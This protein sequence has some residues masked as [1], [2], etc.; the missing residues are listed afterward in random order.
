M[1]AAQT[2]R[3]VKVHVEAFCSV[4]QQLHVMQEV[5]DSRG[6][7]AHQKYSQHQRAGLDV[8]R[9]V[10][11]RPVELADDPAKTRD[12]D[13][14]RRQEAQGGQDKVVVEQEV[15][16]ALVQRQHVVAGCAVQL[17][18]VVALLHEKLWDDGRRKRHPQGQADPGGAHPLGHPLVHERVRHGQVA[19]DADA[20]QRQSRTVEVA[21]ETGGDQPTGGLSES[22]VVAMEMIADLEQEGDEEEEVG[23][24]Q[25]A[26]ED[27]RGHLSNFSGQQKQ[28]G[29][30]GRDPDRDHDDV[31][32]GDDPGAQRAAEVSH[33]AVA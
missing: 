17:G 24:G 15:M 33:R 16:G 32:D 9:P 20:G 21:I 31:N 1:E 30:V 29:H 10:Q 22:P 5:K 23:D 7:E 8:H 2:H 18:D 25:A 3:Q 26:V 13:H 12:R 4:R 27:G 6:Q 11:V 14:Q 19:L 28:D